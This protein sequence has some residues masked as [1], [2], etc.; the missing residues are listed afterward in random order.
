MTPLCIVGMA[1]RYADARTPA[2]LWENVLARRQAFRRIPS[3]RLRL[4]DYYQTDRS[5]PDAIYST[6]AAVI[7]G[8]ELDR[9]KYRI[10]GN[11]YRSTDMTHW[12]A[13]DVAAQALADAGFADGAGLP[14]ESTGVIVGN[15]LTGE[16]SRANLM[17]LRWPYVRR[18]LEATPP[19]GV[20]GEG[21][22]W[23]DRVEDAY[24]S[25]FPATS[26]E[27]LAG[28]LSNTLAGRIANYFNLN[29]G[30]YT[31]DGACAASLLA[32]ANGANALVSGDLDVA[33]VGG[34][35]LS[36]DP[37]ELV[38]FAKCGALAAEEMR[39]FDACSNGF[40]PGEGCGFV[41]LMRLDDALARGARPYAQLRGW[42]VSSDGSG[43]LTRPTASGQGLALRRAYRRAGCPAGSVAYF[44]AH[45][46][47]TPVGDA[48]ELAALD[49]A[50][51]EAPG[52]AARAV[53]S[54]IKANIGHTKA[55]AGI[56]GVIK[57]AMS[58]QSQILPPTASANRT[59]ARPAPHSAELE[60]LGAPE[61]WPGDLPLL[62]GVSAMG[63][64]G[65]NAH[66]VIQGAATVRRNGFSEREKLI[67]RSAQDA[68]LFVLA[69]DLRSQARKLADIAG[70]L[71]RCELSDL[72]I[73]LARRC[74]SEGP[75]AA[76][77]ADSP[78]ALAHRALLLLERLD[79]GIEERLSAA[80]GVYF[81]SATKRLGFL[82]PGQGGSLNLHGGAMAARFPEAAEL[83]VT[84]PAPAHEGFQTA[85]ATQLSVVRAGLAA[86]RVLR[87][88]GVQAD[89][90]VG[91]SLGEL[92]A[93][94]WAGALSEDA[95][96]QLAAAR[97][98]AMDRFAGSGTML[99]L[100][101]S[102]GDAQDLTRGTAAVV[103]AFNG[104]SRTVVSGAA[105]DLSVVAARARAARIGATEL[106]VTHPFHSPLMETA[107][108]GFREALAM[109]ALQP[110]HRRI[111]STV[112]GKSLPL[113][114][115]LAHLLLLQLTAPVRFVEAMEAAR[116]EADVFLEVGAG[117]MLGTLA[118]DFIDRPVFATGAGH[119]SIQ[120]LLHALAAAHVCGR[121]PQLG[122]LL[123]DRFA[124]PISLDWQPRFLA[125]PCESV[126]AG[127]GTPERGAKPE[128]AQHDTAPTDASASAWEVVR[129][130]VARRADLPAECIRP[131]SRLLSDL[132][133]NSLLVAEL[134]IE[135]A[136]RMKLPAP[137]AP[138]EF[139][140]A[141]AGQVAQAMEECKT[142][143]PAS[144]GE[145]EAPR[146]VDAWVRAFRI[147]L[148]AAE[149]PVGLP[150]GGS[151]EWK[152]LA[153]DGYRW[154]EE[155]T[156]RFSKIAGRGTVLCLEPNPGEAIIPLLLEA[157]RER[158]RLLVVQHG[159][160]GSA[161]AKT[162]Y[163]E[164]RG[165]A[166]AVVD[167]PYTSER[168]AEWAAAE[169]AQPAAFSEAAYDAA[170]RR[171]RPVLRPCTYSAQPLELGPS[172]VL[173]VTGGG[174]GI[175]AE[176]A[177]ELARATGVHLAIVG[178]SSQE[179]DEELAANLRRMAAAGA[180]ARYFPADISDLEA[181]RVMVRQAE[182]SLGPITAIL[183]GAGANV[184]KLLAGLTPEQFRA[185]LA[186][187]VTGL[188]NVLACIDGSR[189]RLCLAFGSL[190]ARTGLR[191]EGDYAVA[192]EWLRLRVEAWAARHPHCRCLTI[193]WSVWSG[194]GMGQRLGRVETL[195]QNGIAA[196]PVAAAVEILRQLSLRPPAGGSVV[197]TGRFGNPPTLRLDDGELPML[198]F[199][200]T[201]R[202]HYPAI[203]LVS[204]VTI[205]GDTDLYLD[206]HRLHGQRIFP[207]V[208]GLEAMAQAAAAL[209]ARE[210]VA[211]ED[212]RFLRPITVGK[213][214]GTR[215]RIA[216]LARSTG[217]I[218]VA[219]RTE[220]TSFQADHFRAICK[221]ERS[222]DFAVAEGGV[223]RPLCPAA[224]DELYGSILFQSGRFRRVA[225]YLELR[226]NKC[227]AEFDS[228]RGVED[229][230]SGY[231][232]PT[233]LLGDAG[234]RDAA[235]HAIQAC[236]PHATVLPVAVDR[237]ELRAPI[238]RA[239]YAAARELRRE[240][241]RHIYELKI[242]DGDGEMLELWT[243]LVLQEAGPAS[244][245]G[246]L[247]GLLLTPFLERRVRE[248]T[249]LEIRVDIEQ[250]ARNGHR[251]NRAGQRPDGRP[252]N[253]SAA[254]AG[255]FRL[256]VSSAA[257]V[258]CDL[259]TVQ[260]R[261]PAT[262]RQLLGREQ[263][264][265]A[266]EIAAATGE[267]L[268][269]ASTR[270]WTA[271]E[272]VK[273]I[274]L[275]DTTPLLL[276]GHEGAFV[277]L[278]AGGPSIATAPAQLDDR[279]VTWMAAVMVMTR[280]GAPAVTLP[281]AT[282]VAL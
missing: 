28:G 40:W 111:V 62:A 84:S 148:Q 257:H 108:P 272:V 269:A 35:D 98:T 131:D 242:L 107:A 46:T 215:L 248:L 91:H 39:V 267:D 52:D 235:I 24:K 132:H 198:R 137:S 56:A 280:A 66:V 201:P 177:L 150:A 220:H 31:V 101:A 138:L 102:A 281:H 231:L 4:E 54:S 41:V 133:L 255:N 87:A 32:V 88:A 199:V 92:T 104:L 29:G 200:G 202:V 208:L 192:N 247:P 214:R 5:A 275:A 256:S 252:E 243:G 21:P 59:D 67:I 120:P 125:N 73:E 276:A 228:G 80:D 18:V 22:E 127:S 241:N 45:G 176:C 197:V 212:V 232:P 97:G 188:E 186:P 71:A 253:G 170:G 11:T 141:T 207:A 128:V 217:E 143:A 74:G 57:A 110:L 126:A 144:A 172:D 117:E 94:H 27:S 130:L 258:A 99:A 89:V 8:F 265:L 109:A 180:I 249:G 61:I 190:I 193:E 100:A 44:E 25:P 234:V 189:L 171:Y 38:G 219:I 268:D 224:A 37:F 157:A 140:D 151:G 160:G 147:E 12:L 95:L 168:V 245:H 211:F 153:D 156:H 185:T 274:G 270:V 55:A 173:L 10:S 63:F 261:P 174:K 106:P 16:F 191:G 162:F 14:R 75:W 227:V 210:T 204:D 158:E 225:R 13:L 34:V 203:E 70:R 259:E 48:V 19:P 196:L 119:P 83:L 116:S 115:D 6:Q 152:L 85:E 72:S 179:S 159:G 134:I 78:E 194:V 195:A 273:K 114:S 271:K 82:F 163:Q 123:Q 221:T 206:D 81:G 239:R 183:H 93:L 76:I 218:E 2:E 229:W 118:G 262:W 49:A 36:I 77:V 223:P 175:S 9:V 222:P 20:N 264:L 146:G 182:A 17:R 26:E 279:D 3:E 246:P 30:A 112:T 178:R 64:G 244:I 278:S 58:V 113:D 103:A 33:L 139:A 136:R 42:G 155:I 149:A 250:G 209:G 230:Y 282:G 233:F 260:S 65:I 216:A 181:T 161:F 205:S 166:V 105:K 251:R 164:A 226:S 266:E 79:D 122:A 169:A 51:R 68:E 135:I 238:E 184:P 254:Y 237:I 121:A 43:G 187:K 7:E 1:C 15:T 60:V 142:A 96:L 86:L 124:R 236:I 129:E 47:G 154:K 277:V 145:E 69:G 53:V 50:R 167:A 23:L 90:A 240:G 165:T 213:D 263:F